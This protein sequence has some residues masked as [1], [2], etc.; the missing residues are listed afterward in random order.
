MG[1]IRNGA[2]SFLDLAQK[3]CKLSRIPGFRAGLNAIVGADAALALFNTWEPFCLVVDGLI[4]LDNWYNKQDY[5]NDDAAG[6]DIAP[7]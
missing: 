3:M 5:V 7:V 2:R 1:V 6:E 4:G